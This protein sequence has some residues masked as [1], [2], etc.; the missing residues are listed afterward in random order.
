MV[1]CDVGANTVANYPG[2][3]RGTYN[4]A[5]TGICCIDADAGST[6]HDTLVLTGEHALSAL[7]YQN[8]DSHIRSVQVPSTQP[9]RLPTTAP[10]PSP[11]TSPTLAPTNAP[12]PVF[13]Q[14]SEKRILYVVVLKCLRLH[15]GSQSILITQ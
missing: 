15:T 7:S 2:P 5:D 8:V 3:N 4:E 12:T 14:P 9:S 6:Q 13:D 11:T 1:S 10:T